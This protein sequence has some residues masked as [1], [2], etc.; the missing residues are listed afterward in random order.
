MRIPSG[1]TDQVIYFVAV[2]A[3]DF[4]TRETG[5]S[6]FTVY[7]D[8][9]GG[10]AAAMTTP[11]VTEVD[12]TNMPGVYKL[13][14]D[15][16]MTIGSGNDN[17]EMIFHISHAGMAPVS[18]TI[19]LY[20][21][22]ITVGNTLGVAADG[23]ISG[24]VDGAVAS[25][26]GNVGGNVVG[27]VASVT[28]AVGSVTGNV[29]GNVVGSVASVT[30]NVGGIAGTIQTLDALDTAQDTQHS[31]T[32]SAISALNNLSAADVNTQADTALSDFF[33]SAAALVDL[34]WDE[35]TSGHSTA[36]TTGKA[37]T[38]AGS[39]GDPWSTALPGAYGVG[40][41]G[42]ILGSV[43][44]G[45]DGVT[46]A[47]SQ[48][49]YAPATVTNLNTKIPQNLNLTASGNIG[50]NWAAV[51]NPSTS[52]TLSGTTVGTATTVTNAVTANVTLIEGVD[53][54]DQINA[55]CD[56]AI[57]TY[58]LHY[59]L[60]TALPT[61]W[62]TNVTANSALDYLADDGTAT[63]DRTTDSMQAL[64]D[65]IGNGTNLTEA[66]GTG[67]HLTGLALTGT[68]TFNITGNITG[69]LSGSVGSVTGAVGSV[70][71]AVGS[72]TGAV[73]SISGVTFPANFGDLSITATTGRVDV[74][75]VTGTTQT[76]GD[77]AALIT[78]V[79]TVVD[80]I[81]TD[82]SNGTDGLGAIKTQVAAIEVDT[83]DIQ[84]RIPAALVGGRMDANMGAISGSATAA[85]L[86]EASATG[87]L[88]GQAQTG[89]L[90]TTSMTTDLSG[91]AADILIGRRIV[92]T[93]GSL[94]YE[95]TDITDYDGAGLL[96][97]SAL[98]SAPSN[99]DNFVVV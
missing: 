95:A 60:H 94:K 79:D 89:T 90:T 75:K 34:I 97:F 81:Q 39:A 38:D 88:V 24:N 76:A 12:A 10:G 15:E 48:P 16:D 96:T 11:T 86:L 61:G 35:P 65:W 54:T 82:L 8:R 25:V 57:E 56:A 42:N 70:T 77:L 7:R 19:E 4:A 84:S 26:T 53:A 87:I 45:T 52:V 14:L 85:D 46:L 31:T 29:G 33:T 71:G 28:G 67:D 36:G 98:T 69:N 18:R 30:G 32:Q 91:I 40:T 23:D 72:V 51:E 27:S 68:Q 13:L 62:G 92:F 6:S 2:D 47:T 63:F 64:R 3:T 58:N 73:G 9:N 5:L 83:Q 21:P 37:L 1:T 59:I 49:N 20:R 99:G 44:A 17:E 74:G 22:K 43:I 80:G 78:T 50:V 66:G 41:A 55:A 93:T